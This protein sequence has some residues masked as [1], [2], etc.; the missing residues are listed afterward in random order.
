MCEDNSKN[1]SVQKIEVESKKEVKLSDIFSSIN[2]IQ[3]ETIDSS[4][5]GVRIPHLEFYKERFFV[6]DQMQS[7]KNILCFNKDGKFLYKIDK[8]GQGPQEYKSL[9]NFIIDKSNGLIILKLELGRYDFYDLDGNYLSTQKVKD[10]YYPAQIISI[11]RDS[12]LAYNDSRNFPKDHNL[13]LLDTKTFNIIDKSNIE[14]ELFPASDIPYLSIFEGNVL[15]YSDNDT[16]YDLSNSIHQH[17]PR[18]VLA[19]D[20][21][22]VSSKRNLKNRNI[23]D[24]N[25]LLQNV[26]NLLQNG[27]ITLFVSFSENEKWLSFNLWKGNKSDPLPVNQFVLYDKE[28]RQSYLSENIH[29]DMLN[30]DKLY[31]LRIISSA[32]KKLF[33]LFDQ[34]FSESEI[35]K[36]KEGS[37]L[38]E[39]DKEILLNRDFADNPILICLNN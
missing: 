37:F 17:I 23:S 35:E 8:T 28:N 6:L 3:L 12:C 39:K 13:L 36:I 7:H 1:E 34:V 5:V 18:Y 24:W 32:P 29:Y 25:T 15:C 11:N 38:S 9:K 14:G 30:L 27:E 20:K 21:N 4:L 33:C 16:I 2:V 31:N 26:G 19:M 10:I 22:T